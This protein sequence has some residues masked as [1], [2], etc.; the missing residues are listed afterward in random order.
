MALSP[1][2]A[3]AAARRLLLSRM[4]LLESHGFFGL[5]LMHMTFTLDETLSTAATD[6]ERIYWNPDFLSDL[7]DGEVDFVMM[8]EI[9]HAVLLHCA[10]G[11]EYDPYLFN[12][13]ADIVVNSNILKA[14]NMDLSSITLR[15][16]GESM[17]KTP[18][19]DEGYLYTA[20]EVYHML[21]GAGQGDGSP[22]R[23]SSRAASAPGT[24]R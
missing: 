24:R 9:L 12:I 22:G 15:K 13:A 11:A 8:H 19:K 10:R 21:L 4:R 16:Y 23:T 7:S 3:K 20:E 6:G 1:D 14:K 5:L 18:K 2:I 17:H